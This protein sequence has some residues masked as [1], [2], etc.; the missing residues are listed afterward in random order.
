M[1][2]AASTVTLSSV[3]S[4]F[5]TDEVVILQVDVEIG[6]DQAF[7][8]QRPDDAGH[9]VA[10]QF[11]DRVGDLDDC[12]EKLLKARFAARN[13]SYGVRMRRAAESLR[14]DKGL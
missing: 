2:S 4:R 3:A 5:S 7:L 1:A 9:L 10:V 12:H 13:A 11:D 14:R 6:Q 8:D